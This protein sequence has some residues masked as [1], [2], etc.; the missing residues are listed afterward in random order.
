MADT[1]FWKL[2]QREP[3]RPA[4]V[5]ADGARH[6]AGELLAR[7]N[8]VVH[9]LRAL[10][11][12]AGRHGR[13]GAR[14]RGGAMLE[15]SLAAA[16]AGFYLT[17]I[18]RHLTAPEIA[19]ILGDCDAR[20]VVSA[21]AGARRVL[22]APMAQAR[23]ASARSRRRRAGRLPPL[24][25]AQG[26]AAGRRCRPS[27]APGLVMTYTSGT[28]GAPRAC[29]A[30]C[31]PIAPDVI[32]E[33][34]AM[35]LRLFGI[36]PRRGRAP[37]RLAALPHGGAQLLH[38]PPALRRTRVVLMDKWTPEG[39]LE[40]IARDRVTTSHMVPT[41]F[42]RL[43]ALPDDV[44]RAA[45]PLVAAPRD[46]Q[47]RALPR[48]RE[49][50]DARLVGHGHLR[51][52][53]G[54]RGRRHAGDARRSGSRTRAPS[55]RRG[56]SRSCASSTTTARRARRGEVGTVYMSMGDYTLRV[57][58]GQEEDRR[59]PGRTASSPSATP[60]TST[61]TASSSSAIARPT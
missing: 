44:K 29:A 55:A 45:R 18:N 53:R 61:R 8:R 36:P 40:R 49:A 19:Y 34:N 4:L 47:R 5:E 39:T 32:G 1:G 24:R 7:R 6:T 23:L 37:R 20:A 22:S 31:R 28:T 35:F 11:L 41:Q 13:G 42:R 25:G 33:R 38:Q 51:V 48:R 30:R 56:R 17:P 26:R 9:G 58:Q 54:V 52:L 14:Q 16:Q 59:A 43:L 21:R 46:P 3:E 57:P 15:L 10:G 60:A 2:A 12:A 50:A 27:A